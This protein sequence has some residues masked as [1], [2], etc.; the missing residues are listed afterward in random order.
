MGTVRIKRWVASC[1]TCGFRKEFITGDNAGSVDAEALSRNFHAQVT[2]TCTTA[3][4]V[5]VREISHE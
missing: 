1:V 5:R 2:P 3:N 4:N